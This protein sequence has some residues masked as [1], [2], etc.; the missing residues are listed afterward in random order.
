MGAV[1]VFCKNLNDVEWLNGA[2]C[3]YNCNNSVDVWR[4]NISSHLALSDDFLQLLSPGEITRA[5]KYYREA[6]RQRSIVSRGALRNILGK[7]LGLSPAAVQFKATAN[8]KP[9]VANSD[10]P[11]HYNLSHSGDWI[12]LAVSDNEIG[13]DVEFISDTFGYQEILKDN[14][15]REETDLINP[16]GGP[17][18]FFLLWTRKEALLKATGQG[19]D[20]D[21]SL[22]PVT[23]GLNLIDDRHLSST[24][25]WQLSSFRVD[26]QYTGT[27][28]YSTTSAPLAFWHFE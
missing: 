25:D 18:V 11:I 27:V 21:L 2:L 8:K 3:G 5:N 28:A 10:K 14:F 23:D 9:F 22:I 20:Q 24:N 17:G 13:A 12:L 19:L 7:Y 16:N 15:S 6:D 26:G 4:I 1:K